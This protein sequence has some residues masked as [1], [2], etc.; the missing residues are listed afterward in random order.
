MSNRPS[1]FIDVIH[2]LEMCD[3]VVI[4]SKYYP[5]KK[6]VLGIFTRKFNSVVA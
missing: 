6:H 1:I 4:Y 2:L 3:M 5:N